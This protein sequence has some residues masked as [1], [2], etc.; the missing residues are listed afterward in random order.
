LASAYDAIVIGAGVMGASIAFHLARAG[1]DNTLVLERGTVCSGNTR[2]S[3]ALVRMHY[4]N[5]PEASLALASL[6][7]F[8]EWGELVGYDCGFRKVGFL[9]LV[10][11]KNRQRLERNVA[12]QRSLGINTQMLEGDDLRELQPGIELSDGAV[13]AFEPDSGYA[14]PV[15]TT[16]SFMRSAVNHGVTILEH[17][18]V[19]AI[20]QSGGRVVGVST[21]DGDFDAPIV[22]CA[23]NVWSPVLLRTAGVELGL[24]PLR[25]QMAFFDRP[26]PRQA[27]PHVVLDLAQ[28]NY[29]RP[30]GDHQL[31]IG[32]PLTDLGG[33]DP[34]GYDQQVTPDYASW[35]QQRMARRLPGVADAIPAGGQ[36]GLYDMSPDTRA[37]LDRAPGVDGLFIAAGFSGSG[38]KIS[39]IVGACIAELAAAG[40]A[41]SADIRPFRFNRFAEND[42][43][44]GEDEYEL[45]A[46]WGMKW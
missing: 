19:R 37:I 45:P 21:G 44:R 18:T 9:L 10:G 20:R 14:D 34:D 32:T 30:H 36:A 13:G 8:H 12:M 15:A 24:T 46:S 35:V 39:P 26:E 25:S 2:K 23:A 41:T 5:R 4:S 43:I 3:G 6:R 1:L 31:L 27:M 28:I 16:V 7:Y 38:F 42:P 40:R 17:V 29:G 11:P 33:V 22:V